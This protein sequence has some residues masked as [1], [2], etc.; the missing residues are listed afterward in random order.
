MRNALPILLVP[1]QLKTKKYTT[2]APPHY[3]RMWEISVF[4][5]GKFKNTIDGQ[6]YFLDAG[7]VVLLGEPHMHS[8]DFISGPNS[9]WDLYISDSE[10]RAICDLIDPD[11]Y[12]KIITKQ[13]LVR[14]KLSDSRLQYF[15][16]DLRELCN[17]EASSKKGIASSFLAHYLLGIYYNR[18]NAE[19]NTMPHWLRTLLYNLQSSVFFC[20]KASD[21]IDST[22]YSPSQFSRIFKEYTGITLIEY[23]TKK[24]ME[25]A[26]ELLL[27][28]E[29]PLLDITY[30]LGYTSLSFFIKLFKKQYGITPLQYRIQNKKIAK[31]F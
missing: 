8:L 29:T 20:Q 16:R 22:G 15:L 6:Q 7:D 31:E 4:E 3:H 13:I 2:P 12:E 5:S 18:W 21:I 1:V 14:F 28:T 26:I 11:F 25:Y 27:K 23:L 24:R 17:H 10:M 19:N 9:Y 30:T